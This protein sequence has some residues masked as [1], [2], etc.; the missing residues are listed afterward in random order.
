[1]T[2][3]TVA[4]LERELGELGRLEHCVK[5]RDV[6][7]DLISLTLPPE[8][9][10]TTECA[11]RY[12]F[13]RAREGSGKRRWLR[14]LTPYVVGIQDALDSPLYR[15]VV[16]IG[17]GRTGKSVAGENKLFKTLRVGPAVDAIVY[18]QAD[19]DVDSYADK[20]FADFFSERLHPEIAAKVGKRPQDNKR[21]FKYVAGRSVQLLPANEGNVRQKEATYIWASEIDGYRPKVRDGF[22]DN[23]GVRMQAS[24]NQAKAYIESHPDLGEAGPIVTIYKDSTRGLWYWPCPH[25]DA[26]ASPHPRAP[27]GM[28]MALV[29]DRDNDLDDDDLLDQVERTA[30]LGCPHCGTVIRDEHKEAM[31]E[32]G[33]WVHAG[34]E[35]TAAGVVTGQPRKSDTAGFWLHGTMSPFISFG[36]MAR[37]DVAALIHYERTR[38]PRRLKEVRVKTFGETYEGSA[39]SAKTL[40]DRA[41]AAAQMAL[42]LVG[43]VPDEV[44]FITSAVDVGGSKFD[45]MII[46]WDLEGRSWVIERFT[47]KQRQTPRGMIDLRTAE[48]IEDWMILEQEVLNRVLPL[49]RDPKLRM[50]IAGMAIDTGDGHVTEKA[51]EFARR[52]ARN[53]QYWGKAD[54]PWQK[55]RLIKGAKLATAPELPNK[56]RPVSVDEHGQPVSPTVLEYDLGVFK[57]KEQTVER[58]ALKEDGPGYVRFAADLPS[59]MYDEFAGEHLADGKWER[60]GPNESLDLFGYNEAVRLM[61]KPDRA[62]IRW[63][64][65]PPVWAR[66]I[67]IV[68]PAHKHQQEGSASP[69]TKKPKSAIDRLAALNRK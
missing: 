16:C 3:E 23:I 48:R 41:E 26:W 69:E 43:V 68:A 35:I 58:L 63:D 21:E 25:C 65:A 66:P 24:G 67:P 31:N 10:S 7:A 17:P 55:V 29:Y 11:E 8:D 61:L 50:P 45:V 13:M 2:F 15:F 18:L 37:K 56:P 12:R 19:G 27:K 46:G 44:V 64:V 51:R 54:N 36:E 33:V 1:M 4:L 42:R 38:R 30:G 9:L 5:A 49:E 39:A 28:Y 22:K 53:G 14:K 52:M 34:Q 59:S 62:A 57:L 40:R 47:L 60:T 32:R 20:E 6:A